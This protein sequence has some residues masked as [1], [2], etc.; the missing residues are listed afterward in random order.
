[1]KLLIPGNGSHAIITTPK[2]IMITSLTDAEVDQETLHFKK[3][4]ELIIC[5]DSANHILSRYSYDVITCHFLTTVQGLIELSIS[6]ELESSRF[7]FLFFSFLFFSFLF[8]SFLFFSFLYLNIFFF[9]TLF[10]N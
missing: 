4:S 9:V 2:S 1:M 3:N 8:F 5:A 6:N 10:H 7:S